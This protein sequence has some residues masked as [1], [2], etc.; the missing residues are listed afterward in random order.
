MNEQKKDRHP[1][2]SRGNVRV[3]LSRYKDDV[4]VFK[5]FDSEISTAIAHC[6]L[7]LEPTREARTRRRLMQAPTHVFNHNATILEYLRAKVK[8]EHDYT[9]VKPGD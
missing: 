2:Q 8:A 6:P 3:P 9:P 5:I 1:G 7:V 4:A